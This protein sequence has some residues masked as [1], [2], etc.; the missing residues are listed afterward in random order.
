MKQVAAVIIGAIAGTGLRLALTT[1]SGSL[2]ATLVV[3]VVGALALG[4]LVA[5]LWPSAPTWLRAGLGTGLLGSFTTFS[6]LAVD[7]VQLPLGL[8]ALYLVAT[9]A[10]GFAAAFAGLALGR[11]RKVA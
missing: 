11:P 2:V 7:L 8:A 10:L 5:R 4:F 6:A 3:N 9:L 1:L